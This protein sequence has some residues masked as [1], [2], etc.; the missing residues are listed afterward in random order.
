MHLFKISTLVLAELNKKNEKYK[1]YSSLGLHN[2]LVS[3]I[4]NIAHSLV[5]DLF[6]PTP[7]FSAFVRSLR[8]RQL[9]GP[10]LVA[11]SKEY[12]PCLRVLLSS[13]FTS[14]SGA[15]KSDYSYGFCW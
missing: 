2:E 5:L 13:S 14:Y 7:L 12:T 1:K 6:L 11:I 15:S 4:F 8:R 9:L 3:S 10:R